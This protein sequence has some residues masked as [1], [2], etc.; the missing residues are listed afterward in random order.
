MVGRN[1]AQAERLCASLKNYGLEILSCEDV[2]GAKALL[3]TEKF[4]RALVFAAAK[5]DSGNEGVLRHLAAHYPNI[6]CAYLGGIIPVKLELP[7]AISL[8]PEELDKLSDFLGIGS[9]QADAFR[10]QHFRKH[11]FFLEHVQVETFIQ[12]IMRRQKEG[13]EVLGHECLARAQKPFEMW[14]PEFI[15]SYAAKKDLLFETDT[16]CLLTALSQLSAVNT[17]SKLFINLRPRTLTNARIFPF[18][19]NAFEKYNIQISKVVFELTE[20]QK[21]LNH[22]E[23]LNGYHKLRKMGAQVA[24]DD[25]GTGFA[26][27]QLIQVLK[28][29]YIKMSGAFG[30]NIERLPSKQMIVESV[31]ELG[32]KFGI[33][34]IVESVENA[35]ALATIEKLGV[36]LAQGYYFGKPGPVGNYL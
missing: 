15:F 8:L 16:L 5:H 27:L 12:P 30:Q 13:W 33:P 22:S 1:R 28:P 29:D 36:Q 7:N 31:A 4:D 19:K 34:V 11:E 35:A 6:P 25:F 24:L 17:K 26:N 10:H 3:S 18:L 23:F 2:G 32:T 9:C 21:I 20:Q 14:N